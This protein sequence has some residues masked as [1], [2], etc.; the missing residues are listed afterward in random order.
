MNSRPIIG[1]LTQPLLDHDKADPRFEGYDS[2][3]MKTYVSF[4]ESAGARVVPL[5]FGSDFE[6]EA[7]K[8]PHLN[9]VFYAGGRAPDDY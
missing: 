7:A 2:F 8:L 4:L 5:I 9:G 3:I 1:A 6:T